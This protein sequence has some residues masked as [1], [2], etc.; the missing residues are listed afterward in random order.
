MRKIL[1]P[2]L[3]ILTLVL[4][5]LIALPTLAVDP[6]AGPLGVA[7]MPAAVQPGSAETSLLCAAPVNVQPPDSFVAVGQY[8]LLDRGAGVSPCPI[9]IP[10]ETASTGTLTAKVD[11]V[12]HLTWSIRG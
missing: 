3:C 9:I 2:L 12:S 10:M 4:I 8:S 5:C 1:I 7:S 6:G 11:G